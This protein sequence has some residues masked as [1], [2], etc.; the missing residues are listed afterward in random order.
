MRRNDTI[1]YDKEGN[2]KGFTKVYYKLPCDTIT[3]VKE[4]IKKACGWK[5]DST[6]YSKLRG[7][8]P[9]HDHEKEIMVALFREYGIDFN[10]GET[11]FF[12]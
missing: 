1:L 3:S 12:R 4:R 10:T 2:E 7:M 8:R 6:F 11:I 9:V 5:S